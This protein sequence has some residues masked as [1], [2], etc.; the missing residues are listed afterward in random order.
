MQAVVAWYGAAIHQVQHTGGSE[1]DKDL[2]QLRSARQAALDDLDRL[3]LRVA[4]P[5][6]SSSLPTT[7]GSCGT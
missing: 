1:A 5:K 2:L 6:N 3:D 7:P 4:P